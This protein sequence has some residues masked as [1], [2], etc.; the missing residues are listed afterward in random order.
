MDQSTVKPESAETLNEILDV[1]IERDE[2]SGVLSMPPITL[3]SRLAAAYKRA[4]LPC[5]SCEATATVGVLL[6]QSRR[7]D[8]AEYRVDIDTTCT[9]QWREVRNSFVGKLVAPLN[10]APCDGLPVASPAE[11]REHCKLI[12]D[13]IGGPRS[14]RTLSTELMTHY[15]LRANWRQVF[16]ALNADRRQFA[17]VNVFEWSLEDPAPR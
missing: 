14:S 4:S 5:P 2:T 3:S 15:K 1:S 17:R 11:I 7:T 9:R 8:G 10:A 12:L 16:E 6:V 13:A